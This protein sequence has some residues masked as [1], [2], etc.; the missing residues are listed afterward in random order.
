MKAISVDDFVVGLNSIR[1]DEFVVGNVLDFL[2]RHPLAPDSLAPYLHF[3][4]SHY[5]RNLIHRN[6][7]FEL[8]AICWEVGQASSIH[9][10]QGQNCWMTAP[11]GRLLVQNFAVEEED[12]ARGYCKLRTTNAV[13]MG[14]DSPAEVDPSAPVHQVLNQREYGERAVSLH[15]YSRPYDTCISYDPA[16]E[17]CRE[18]PLRYFSEAGQ[19]APRPSGLE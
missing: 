10:H 13:E 8:L 17:A 18:I 14:P 4:R 5:T 7:L 2:R 3:D 19:V 1:T 6:A 9:N 12:L 11:V 16:R 15:I